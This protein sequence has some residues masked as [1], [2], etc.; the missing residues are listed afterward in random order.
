MDIVRR[1]L[2]LVTIG[3][4]RV[5]HETTGFEIQTRDTRNPPKRV[6]DSWWN[7][8]LEMLAFEERGKPEY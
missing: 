8:S 7:W 1:K 2:M 6:S 5:I 3:T 4:Q